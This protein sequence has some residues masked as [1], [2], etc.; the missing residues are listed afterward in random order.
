MSEGLTRYAG[1]VCE[2]EPEKATG[3]FIHG[4][5]KLRLG[6]KKTPDPFIDELS[7]QHSIFV[8]LTMPDGGNNKPGSLGHINDLM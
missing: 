5:P 4:R 3:S 7:V 2:G 1:K 6:K 8:M